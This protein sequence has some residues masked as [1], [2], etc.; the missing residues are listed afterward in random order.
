MSLRS[1]GGAGMSGQGEGDM[2]RAKFV[3]VCS[4]GSV[5]NVSS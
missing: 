3:L 2:G 1:S 5:E 4:M